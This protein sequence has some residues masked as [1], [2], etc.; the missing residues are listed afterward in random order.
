MARMEWYESVMPPYASNRTCSFENASGFS[1]CSTHIQ[2]LACAISGS[3]GGD[4]DN[5]TAHSTTLSPCCTALTPRA[6][7]ADIHMR[8][9][10][11]ALRTNAVAYC[12]ILS[13][14]V[15]DLNTQSLGPV[16]IAYCNCCSVCMP[17]S[18]SALS[19]IQTTLL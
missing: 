19:S 14:T 16:S 6:S 1:S 11:L 17:N 13:I 2:D 8:K 3:S 12:L 5:N 18:N 9:P 4:I 15:I 10:R 7:V